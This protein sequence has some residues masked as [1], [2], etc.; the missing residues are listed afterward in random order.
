MVLNTLGPLRFALGLG[1]T[2]RPQRVQNC[3]MPTLVPLEWNF[4]E[5]AAADDASDAVPDCSNGR[6]A[7]R[8]FAD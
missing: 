7:Q 2:G 4:L 1:R 5:K 6:F 8:A 3:P